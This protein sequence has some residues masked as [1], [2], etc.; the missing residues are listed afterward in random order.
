MSKSRCKMTTRCCGVPWTPHTPSRRSLFYR[1]PDN[2]KRC[3]T[4]QLWPLKTQT[5]HQPLPS[6]WKQINV[7]VKKKKV[8]IEWREG[9]W[10][11]IL[12]VSYIE[13]M[14]VFVFN[15][16]SEMFLSC[17]TCCSTSNQQQD[18]SQGGRAGRGHG[19]LRQGQSGQRRRTERSLNSKTS[20]EQGLSWL[21]LWVPSK[22]SLSSPPS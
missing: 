21:S 17:L 7:L 14:R 11:L 12:T 2:P 13:R 16:C 15:R 4:F 8:K 18:E 9:L 3:L 22:A 6:R 20:S 19:Q 5:F 10:Y 1:N